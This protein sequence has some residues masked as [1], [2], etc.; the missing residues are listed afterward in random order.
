[1]LW[2]ND[3]KERPITSA[4]EEMGRSGR[5]SIFSLLLPL[6]VILAVWLKRFWAGLGL[7]ALAL[8]AVGGIGGLNA[9][10]LRYMAVF[11]LGVV[12]AV[13]LDDLDALAGRIDASR[14][15]VLIWGA[16]TAVAL[17]GLTNAWYPF[18]IGVLQFPI[19]VASAALL[20]MV[21][22]FWDKARALLESKT[23]LWLGAISF[24]LYLAHEPIIVS[25]GL[26]LSPSN[27][28]LAPLIGIPLAILVGWAFSI[29]VEKPSHR[30][31]R[32]VARRFSGA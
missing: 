19:S 11:A 27:L 29:A 4:W 16:L 28:W 5:C 14:R 30:L 24:S 26:I 17:I 32:W 13:K 8:T 10:P 22:A 15:P 2:N 25:L 7:V 1:M 18:R 9:M 23:A 31:T 3:K 20:V 12:M 6:Y 21:A